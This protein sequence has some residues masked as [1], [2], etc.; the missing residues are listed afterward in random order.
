MAR[1]SRSHSGTVCSSSGVHISLCLV[2]PLSDIPCCEKLQPSDLLRLHRLR[3]T[4]GEVEVGPL[5]T[6]LQ[7]I[8]DLIRD[9]L[10]YHQHLEGIEQ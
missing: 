8:L 6:G 2:P 3:I 5:T 4:R 9:S 10:S 7:S 1:G